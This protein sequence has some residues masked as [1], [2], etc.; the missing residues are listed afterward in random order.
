MSQISDLISLRERLGGTNPTECDK[1][2]ALTLRYLTI[3]ETFQSLSFQY[4]ISLN[5]VSYI[6]KGCGK[7][8]RKGC[9]K[10]VE[11]I[12]S[13]FVKVPSTKV[14]W[15]G[16][17]R[18]FEERWNFPRALGAIDRKHIRIQKPKNGG[19]FYYSYRHTH[20]IILMTI[21]GPEYECL[22]ADVGSN[23]RVND[24]GIWNKSILLQGM[25]FYYKGYKINQLSSAMTKKLSNGVKNC[26]IVKCL[27]S[28][29]VYSPASF[30]DCILEDGEV[31]EGEWRTNVVTDSFYSR[32]VPRTGHNASLHAKLVREKFMDYFLNDGAVEW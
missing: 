12:A 4:R 31:S 8:C 21:P 1:R 24:S 22:Y 13:A 5:A 3:G 20:F 11:R 26:L 14:E 30:V 7:A 17:S 23:G 9:G 6:V 2:L 16:I 27:N 28:V 18:K 29:N 25:V 15:L 10:A 19:S 32:Q